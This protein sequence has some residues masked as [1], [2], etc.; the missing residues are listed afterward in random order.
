L[1]CASNKEEEVV[2]GAVWSSGVPALQ[3]GVE[4]LWEVG[5]GVSGIIGVVGKVSVIGVVEVDTI[6]RVQA[7]GVDLQELGMGIGMLRAMGVSRVG[8]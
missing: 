1:L 4:L 2:W 3:G 6:G 5:E 8:V 7:T